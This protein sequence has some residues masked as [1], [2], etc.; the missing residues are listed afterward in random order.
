M[1][2]KS[3]EHRGVLDLQARLA[4]AGYS[5]PTGAF[6]AIMSKRFGTLSPRM[7]G[8][9]FE[10]ESMKL[11]V[12]VARIESRPELIG[13]SLTGVMH[14]GVV[15]SLLD[16]AVGAAVLSA[17]GKP[18]TLDL[19]IDYC[20]PLRASACLLASSVTSARAT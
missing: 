9:G 7:R 20:G 4:E 19:R 2:A 14:G 5:G 6:D 18:A 11:G 10:V 13:D 17:V 16:S 3:P 1:I 12:C 15:T 8:L